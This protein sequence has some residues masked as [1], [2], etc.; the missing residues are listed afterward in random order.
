MSEVIKKQRIS[1]KDMELLRLLCFA[2]FVE[3]SLLIF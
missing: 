1:N 2:A 3:I